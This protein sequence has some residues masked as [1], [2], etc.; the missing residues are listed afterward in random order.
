MFEHFISK[1]VSFSVLCFAFII[2]IISSAD[3][4]AAEE[5]TT[6]PITLHSFVNGQ[7][8]SI[9]N[10]MKLSF[11]KG[12]D[13]I[14]QDHRSLEL[15][16]DI[17]VLNGSFPAFVIVSQVI[18]YARILYA[19][20]WMSEVYDEQRKNGM[21]PS[22]IYM[23]AL[24][25]NLVYTTDPNMLELK[26]LLLSKGQTEAQTYQFLQSEYLKTLDSV[27]NKQKNNG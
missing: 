2:L 23:S 17:H 11:E 24:R 20:Q 9:S 4:A 26:E 14:P 27:S 21:R 10:P 3:L 15:Y 6:R 5:D 8:V 16:E 12:I 22:D 18:N 7:K 1:T 25:F 13:F 19:N